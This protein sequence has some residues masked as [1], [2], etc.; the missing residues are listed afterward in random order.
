MS[1]NTTFHYPLISRGDYSAFWALFTDNFTN[2]L[3]IS[4]VCRF[5][6]HMPDEIVFGRI[7][8]G[9]ALLL[10]VGVFFYSWL[11]HRLARKEQRN[12]VTALPFGIS[13]PV[14]FVYLFGVM[15]PIYWSTGDA[16]AAWQVGLGAGFVGGIIASL[17]ALIGPFLQRVTPRAGM[18]GT[19]C[20]IALVFIG[21]IAMAIIF[22]SPIIIQIRSTLRQ[23]QDDLSFRIG[24]WASLSIGVACGRLVLFILFIYK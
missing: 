23:A 11:A 12:D 6:F 3:V 16:T 19:L 10:C 2:L 15:G 9:A 5:V 7:L 17:G 8:P 14:M 24:N 21:T 20:G 1:E 13:T 4:G 18:L 22:E